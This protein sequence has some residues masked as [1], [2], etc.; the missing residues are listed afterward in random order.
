[1]YNFSN[2]QTHCTMHKK[3]SFPV[4][5]SSVN[6]NKSTGNCVVVRL[7][8]RTTNTQRCSDV[9]ATTS[10]LQRWS[11]VSS[12]LDSRF[13]SQCTMDV[14]LTTFLQRWNLD[15]KFTASLQRRYCDTLCRCCLNVG[16]KVTSLLYMSWILKRRTEYD[17]IEYDV[18]TKTLNSQCVLDV[19]ITTSDR[20]CWPL[21]IDIATLRQLCE[22]HQ[23]DNSYYHGSKKVVKKYWLLHDI[24]LV[25]KIDIVI[26]NSGY[27]F[28]IML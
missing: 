24:C 15:V 8:R 18:E 25:C 20:C 9:D 27:C 2:G 5:I 26:S 7:Q 6:V 13:N 11:N 3:W 14:L 12:S 19:N 23:V 10:K 17:E 22:Q 16:Q 1:M 21:L 4:R 28:P